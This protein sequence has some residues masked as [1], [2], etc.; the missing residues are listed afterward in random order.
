LETRKELGYKNEDKVLGYVGRISEEK[1]LF[2]MLEVMDSL[3]PSFKLL[4]VGEG[5][6]KKK[7]L[8]E[9]DGNER[10]KIIEP[11]YDLG[12]IYRAMDCFVLLSPEE[13]CSFVLLE[14]ISCGL[15]FVAVLNGLTCNLE[16]FYNESLDENLITKNT[17]PK[18]ISERIEEIVL[19]R[20]EAKIRDLKELVDKEF[21]ESLFGQRWADFIV[22][23][24]AEG[25]NDE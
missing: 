6:Q 7:L 24:Y 21:D 11:T 10:I 5:N 13:T 3:D 1:E 14:A 9:I 15:P 8:E 18:E 16:Y 19:N 4:I 22:K 23:S 2:K 12:D 17:N 20:N 25:R